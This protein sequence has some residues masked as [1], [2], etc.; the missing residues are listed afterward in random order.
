[1][2]CEF[3]GHDNELDATYCEQCGN[4][5]KTPSSFGRSPRPQPKKA[6]K[7]TN[8]ALIA[9]III[10]LVVLGVMV[11]YLLTAPKSTGINN[12][13][14]NAV[15]EQ[16][17]LSSGFPVS[18]VPNL[19]Q[20]ISNAG[21]GFNNSDLAL[22]GINFS[23]VTLDKNQCLYILSRGIVMINEGETGNIPIKQ[24]GNAENPYGTVNT[25]TIT[26]A[27][28]VDMAKRTYT[29]MDNNGISPNYIGIKVSG[30][31]DLSTDNLL[32][33]YLK[34]LT[35]YKSTGQLPSSVSIP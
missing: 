32:N 7:S 13:S 21:V 19:A 25:A 23:G 27:E 3:C 1:M 11:G 24:Y 20:D 17:S 6:I 34:I 10:L 31:P 2:K 16:I 35:Q 8:K 33:L 26:Q 12:N 22:N 9:S 18:Q 4:K 29:W 15:K 28:Y 5:L 14:T 30:Q